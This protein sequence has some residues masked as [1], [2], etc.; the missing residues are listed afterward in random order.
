[1]NK[2]YDAEDFDK[3]YREEV[4]VMSR[5]EALSANVPHSIWG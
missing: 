2:D 4:S 3:W 5:P 1:M